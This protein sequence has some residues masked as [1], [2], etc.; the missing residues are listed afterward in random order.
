MQQLEARP[1]LLPEPLET[2]FIYRGLS[3]PFNSASTKWNSVLSTATCAQMV[4]RS[5]FQKQYSKSLNRHYL[6]NV[7]GFGNYSKSTTL[8]PIH[9]ILSNALQNLRIEQYRGDADTQF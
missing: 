4:F 8:R 7:N 1:I 6:N 5:A 2:D 3:R 9:R